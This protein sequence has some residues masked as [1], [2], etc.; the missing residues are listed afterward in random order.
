LK[1]V[2]TEKQALLRDRHSIEV[3]SLLP[4]ALTGIFRI[5]SKNTKAPVDAGS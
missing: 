1:E 3:K 5:L 4:S 2:E